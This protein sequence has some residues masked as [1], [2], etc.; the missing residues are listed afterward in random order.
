MKKL[1]LLLIIVGAIFVVYNRQRLFLRDPLGSVVRD[2]L[3]EDGAQVFVN[4][5]SDVMIENDSPPLY[6]EL[7]AHD[8]H[9]GMPQ[10]LKCIHYVACIMDA[11]LPTLLPLP[12]ALTVHSMTA[13][14]VRFLDGKRETTVTLY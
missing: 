10:N 13:R 11:D 9:T 2:G 5:S 6:T 8:D 3:K 4:Y 1:L 14:S 12:A 7:I